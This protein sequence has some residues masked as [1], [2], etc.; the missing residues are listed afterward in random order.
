M[1]K[2]MKRLLLWLLVALVVIGS[3]LLLIFSQPGATTTPIQESQK[4]TKTV[5]ADDWIRGNK[6]A[7]TTL[8]EY[9]DFQCPACGF[10]E[11][12]IQKLMKELDGKIRLV[13]R[14]YPLVNLHQNA[15]V[16][17]EAAEAAGVQGKFWEM[18]DQLFAKQSEWSNQAPD[19]VVQTFADYAGKLNLD[20]KKFQA[21]L[22]SDTVKK[23]VSDDQ[24]DA[25]A[26]NLS[27]TPS[28][29]VNGLKVNPES[30]E[31]LKGF[32]TTMSTP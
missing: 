16:A 20:V 7:K 12:E 3:I 25:L 18:H 5:T 27:G 11:P 17:A 2:D 22:T 32:V 1:D 29:F 6:D 26:S 9:S 4:L 31:Q 23:S 19:K 21:D 13:Y 15:M 24:A 14:N 10:W 30:Y 8:V 28:F